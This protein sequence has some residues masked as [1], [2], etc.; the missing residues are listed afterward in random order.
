M[1]KK[2]LIYLMIKGRIIKTKVKLLLNP[3]YWNYKFNNKKNYFLLNT[4]NHGNMGDQAIA[5]AEEKILKDNNISFMEFNHN[6]RRR[7]YR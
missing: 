2:K 3:K 5:I 7:V 1:I 6:S 4:P